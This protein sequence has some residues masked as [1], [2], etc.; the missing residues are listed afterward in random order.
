MSTLSFCRWY[1]LLFIPTLL[2]SNENKAGENRNCVIDVTPIFGDYM[3]RTWMGWGC[4][5]SYIEFSDDSSCVFVLIPECYD[6]IG[7]RFKFPRGANLYMLKIRDYG[8][9]KVPSVD[10]LA[11]LE[12]KCKKLAGWYYA[13]TEFGDFAQE[14]EKKSIT[15]WSSSVYADSKEHSVYVRRFYRALNAFRDTDGT[16]HLTKYQKRDGAWVEVWK[17]DEWSGTPKYL[18]ITSD[19]RNYLGYD[20]SSG[21]LISVSVV[22]GTLIKRKIPLLFT[23]DERK[24]YAD[25]FK[26]SDASASWNEMRFYPKAEMVSYECVSG[27]LIASSD[28][29]YFY[30]SNLANPNF[31][32]DFFK[33]SHPVFKLEDGSYTTYISSA[34]G[35][36]DSAN[37]AYCISTCR[38]APMVLVVVDTRVPCV[39]WRYTGGRRIFSQS[40]RISSDDK[41]VAYI[42]YDFSKKKYKKNAPHV[43]DQYR[44]VIEDFTPQAGP[45]IKTE[46][47]SGIMDQSNSGSDHKT[48]TF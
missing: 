7:N 23:D 8:I 21:A 14:L 16:V 10:A 1:L 38:M 42:S 35:F 44:L 26:V 45:A 48:D 47:K 18:G 11:L 27:N 39:A 17:S 6:S 13:C 4:D 41:K 40:F 34:V 46:S 19:G 2:F 24:Q 15:Y 29:K 28:G 9:V 22:N 31:R 12:A 43:P 25:R 3:S 32:H 33:D 20:L 5:Q 36:S 37:Y 30:L